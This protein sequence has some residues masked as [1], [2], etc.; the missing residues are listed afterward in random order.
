MMRKMNIIRYK[1]AREYIKGY[2]NDTPAIQLSLTRDS[3]AGHAIISILKANE[4]IDDFFVEEI[5]RLL[6][7]LQCRCL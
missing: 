6:F 2:M 4:R 5:V 7:D 1:Y 3:D